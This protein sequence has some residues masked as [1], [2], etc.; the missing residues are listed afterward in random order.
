MH[1]IVAFVVD[2]QFFG[3]NSQD[4][5]RCVDHSTAGHAQTGHEGN[6]WIEDFWLGQDAALEK[7]SEQCG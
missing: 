7:L 2:D 4:R 1:T 5:K 6:A 3:A